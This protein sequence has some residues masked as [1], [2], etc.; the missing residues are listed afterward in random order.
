MGRT[1]IWNFALIRASV[2]ESGYPTV[3]VQFN[4]DLLQLITFLSRVGKQKNRTIEQ[5][6]E[7]LDDCSDIYNA[8]EAWTLNLSDLPAR[9]HAGNTIYAKV[10]QVRRK[11]CAHI[12]NTHIPSLNRLCFFVK[13][14]KLIQ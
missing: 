9:V 1:D 6:A 13:S 11:F 3:P 10:S 2:G 14:S 7:N 4:T 12:P 5:D 8:L